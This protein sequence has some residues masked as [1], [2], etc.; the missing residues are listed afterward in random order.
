MRPS[1]LLESPT[2]LRVEEVTGSGNLESLRP[3]WSALWER[4]PGATPF[5]S[6][7]WLLPWW[8]H[9]GGEGLWTLTLRREGR[10]VGLAP[11]FLHTDPESGV[12][13][14]TLL[15]NGVS[16]HLDLL[17]LPEL[18]DEAAAAVLAHLAERRDAW[19]RCDLRDLPASSPLLHAPL[20]DGLGEEVTEEEPCPSLPLPDAVEHLDR[21]VPPRLMEKL[22]YSRRRAER[23]G[24]AHF[25]AADGPEVDD[26]FDALLALHRARWAARGEAG[27]LAD[28]RV[29]RFHR[30]AAHGFAERGWLRLYTMRVGGRLAA[31][32]Y[33]FLA[34]GRAY[35][36]LGGFDPA[37]DRLSPGHLVVLHAL[38][39]AVREGAR[40]FD[41]LRGREPY[42]YAWSAVDRPKRRRMIWVL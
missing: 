22:R 15:G 27:V 39:E 40:E 42:K 28:P 35:Y 24:G 8:R 9:L 21:T 4:S 32:H 20:P 12:R 6:P 25:E 10:L 7:E 18:A 31:A 23:E 13:Q 11:L 29:E 30:E 16:D 41:F 26:A 5:Q 37:L 3:D 17:A 36:Y 14:A 34:K 1:A 19:D 2:A 33:G 38:E